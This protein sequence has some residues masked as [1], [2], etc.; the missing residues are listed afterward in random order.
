M[1]PGNGSARDALVDLAALRAQLPPVR[2]LTP[3]EAWARIK[4]FR[5]LY[6]QAAADDGRR[7]WRKKRG[8]R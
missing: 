4:Q 8:Q 1:S 3:D 5:A 6:Q 2:P 7:R